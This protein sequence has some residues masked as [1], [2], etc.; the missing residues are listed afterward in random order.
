MR[1]ARMFRRDQTGPES[2]ALAGY[3]M[4]ERVACATKQ[5]AME[6]L[7]TELEKIANVSSGSVL[8]VVKTC[9]TKAIGSSMRTLYGL[10]EKRFRSDTHE[11]TF[12]FIYMAPPN[13]S[14]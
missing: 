8:N 12:F 10:S 14:Q 4:P 7:V 13:R 6:L 5:L 2:W 11:T 9:W 3:S 1:K